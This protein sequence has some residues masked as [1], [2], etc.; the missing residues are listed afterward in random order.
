M[1]FMISFDGTFEDVKDSTIWYYYKPVHVTTIKPTHGPKDGYTTVQVWGEGFNDFGD[2]TTCSFGVK[3][4]PAKVIGDNYI[5]C[6][7][8][9]SDVVGKAMPFSVSLNGQQQTRDTVDFW[10]YNDP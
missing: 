7:S 3:S 8:P 6:V 5:T 9:G 2:D 1:T 10:Y 4:V